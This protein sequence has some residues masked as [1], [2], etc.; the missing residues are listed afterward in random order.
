M[1]RCLSVAAGLLAVVLLLSGAAPA[2]DAPYAGTWKVVILGSGQALPPGQELSLFLIKVEEKARGPQLELLSAGSPQFKEAKLEPEKAEGDTLKFAAT[3]PGVTL[4]FTA[5]PPKG[6]KAPKTILGSAE[7]RGNYEFVRLERTDDKELDPDKATKRMEGLEDFAKAM[8]TGDAKEKDTALKEFV[9][10]HAESPL[11]YLADL[12]LA[13]TRAKEEAKDKDVK[14]A[15]DQAI[16]IAANYGPA[17]EA[18]ATQQVAQR[19][20][21]TKKAPA[22]AA[23]YARQAEKVLPAG[24][25]TAQ[26]VA[27]LKV[28]LAALQQGDK[29]EEVKEVSERLA[30]LDKV[31]D[32]EYLKSAVPFKTE[33]YKREG[34]KG[35]VVLVELFTGAQCPPCVAAD[36]AFDA[37]LKTYK[38][39]DVVLL[40]YHQHIPGP[41]PLTNDDTEK[42]SRYYDIEGVPSTYV[43]GGNDLGIGGPKDA[44]KTSFERLSKAINDQLAKDSPAK[45]KLAAKQTGDNIVISAEVSGAK[46]AGDDAKLRLALV[47]ELVRYPGRNGQRFHHHVVRA[48]P[49][50]VEGFEVKDGA[51]K[52]EVKV[53]LADLKKSLTEYLEKANAR[54]PFIDEERPLDLKHLEVVAFVQNDK[55]KEILQA[56]R[57]EVA[58]AEK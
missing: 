21:A 50:G 7:F 43:D 16:R 28:L 56:A 46:D 6:E 14:V 44:G 1:R 25:S 19:L 32:E 52:Q 35:R 42:R 11:A 58:P 15:A 47:E 48:M 38:P 49:G 12:E 18:S 54:R 41:D 37:A 51:A 5:Y 13:S 34:G 36:V 57:V 2:A 22:L 24:A 53:N 8:R 17:L 39:A 33:P 31:L 10:K 40:Q 20:V 23:E 4:K 9:D 27:V 45:I 29:K 30:K 55:T 26:K 3:T